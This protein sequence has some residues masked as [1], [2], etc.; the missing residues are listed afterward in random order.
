MVVT[1]ALGQLGQAVVNAFRD[2]H[3]VIAV[4]MHPGSMNNLTDY[5]QIDLT[6]ESIAKQ[7]FLSEQ[8]EIV[9]HLAAMTNVDGC[10][11]HPEHA[12]E[13]NVDTVKTISKS[14]KNS[15]LV[16]I[17]SDYVFD[18]ENGPYSEGDSTNPVN[19][20]GQNKLDSERIV[21]NH[22]ANWTIIRTNVVF[23]YT[24]QSDA[25][26]VKWVV[27]SLSANKNI[28][29]V[30]DQWNNPTW[31]VS[32]ARTLKLVVEK[33]ILGLYHYGGKDWLNRLEFARMIARIFELDGSLISAI[34]TRELNQAA[35]RPLK[36]GLISSR[37]E[38]KFGALC[39]PLDDCLF[40]IKQRI[41]Q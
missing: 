27:D 23:D 33:N 3:H 19:V 4:D 36:S 7:F 18:G 31:T 26:F 21:Q 38:E 30:D 2:S 1:G 20:Y 39:D 35:R 11:L 34:S 37:I 13:I 5:H 32:L 10:E 16:F 8:P 6:A 22:S 17:S 25:S 15:H 28:R 24:K 41:L 14:A 9:L 12:Q 29:V 40:D